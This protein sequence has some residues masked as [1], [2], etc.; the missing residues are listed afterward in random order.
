MWI[1]KTIPQ[2]PNKIW[3][4]FKTSVIHQQVHNLGAQNRCT[5]H[6]PYFINYYYKILVHGFGKGKKR[7]RKNLSFVYL[8]RKM[9][10]DS[11]SSKLKEIRPPYCSFWPVWEIQN[12]RRRVFEEE[13]SLSHLISRK[14]CVKNHIVHNPLLTF[15]PI[16]P[17]WI[18]RIWISWIFLS[19]NRCYT[20]THDPFLRL[21]EWVI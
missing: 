11:R 20:D 9:G 13:L 18:T 15:Y 21:H 5:N 8:V 2:L 10:E 14:S 7:W 6:F 19:Y 1:S 12:N 3:I 17:I 16:W 4:H